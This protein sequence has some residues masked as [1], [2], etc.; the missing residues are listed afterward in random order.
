MLPGVLAIVALTIPTGRSARV[1]MPIVFLAIIVV[2]AAR[3]GALAGILGVLFT[4]AV[5]A[6]YTPPVNSLQVGSQ[7][8]REALAWLLLGGIVLSHFVAS[9]PHAR[10]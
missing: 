4:G 2:V 9:H 6:W 5:F 3:V 7:D 1:W 8:G 10:H